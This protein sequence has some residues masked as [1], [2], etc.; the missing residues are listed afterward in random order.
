MCFTT[1]W[2][3]KDFNIN[4]ELFIIDIKYVEEK[5]TT[6]FTILFYTIPDRLKYFHT[7][8]ACLIV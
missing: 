6:S 8:V 2:F 5:Q 3:K 4:I 1:D 7:K